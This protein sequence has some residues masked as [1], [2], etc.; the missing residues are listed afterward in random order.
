MLSFLLKLSS[1]SEFSLQKQLRSQL[2]GAIIEGHLPCSKPL[3]STRKLAQQLGVS[4]NTVI[5]TYQQ[6][7]DDGYLTSRQRAGYYINQD[8]IR[9]NIRNS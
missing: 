2:T 7:I 3:P 6:L 4:R 1:D 5:H 9:D 8:M